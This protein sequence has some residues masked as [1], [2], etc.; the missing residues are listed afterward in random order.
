[1]A[2]VNNTTGEKSGRKLTALVFFEDFFVGFAA[3]GSCCLRFLCLLCEFPI[4]A[5]SGS[6]SG[7]ELPEEIGSITTCFLFLGPVAFLSMGAD[8]EAELG[9]GGGAGMLD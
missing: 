5:P 6:S 2:R 4:V 7:S 3:G 1:M 8:I 9:W